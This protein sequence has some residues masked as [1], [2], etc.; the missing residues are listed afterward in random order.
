MENHKENNGFDFLIVREDKIHDYLW[1]AGSYAV[2]KCEDKYLLGYNT[3]RKQWIASR[4]K[5]RMKRE[6]IVQSENFE[7]D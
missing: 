4:T 6:R 7:A 1:L 5:K 3:W 2:I